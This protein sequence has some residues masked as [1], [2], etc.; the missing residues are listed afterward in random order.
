MRNIILTVALMLGLGASAVAAQ[1]IAQDM[2]A[3]GAGSYIIYSD[4]SQSFVQVYRGQSGPDW[5]VDLIPGTDPN[6][7]R[8]SREY[9]DARGQMVR[10]DYASGMSLSFS[11]HNCQRVPGPCIFIQTGTQGRTQQGRLVTATQGGFRYELSIFD[12]QENPVLAE[13]GEI[14]LD[15]MGS[16]RD[17]TITRQD[18]AVMRIRQVQAVYR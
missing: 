6:G 13:S 10:V 5:I 11:P 3:I 18:G 12:S 2:A 15:E 9:R 14:V 1:D 4:G 7:T 8:S 16:I 17:G